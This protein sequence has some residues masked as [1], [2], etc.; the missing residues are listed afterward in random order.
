[1][2]KNLYQIWSPLVF[3]IIFTGCSTEGEKALDRVAE[4]R[5]PKRALTSRDLRFAK[6]QEDTRAKALEVEKKLLVRFCESK[7][8]ND[9]LERYIDKF[10]KREPKHRTCMKKKQEIVAARLRKYEEAAERRYQKHLQKVQVFL[11]K[12]DFKAARNYL[13]KNLRK[14]KKTKARLNERI[15]RGPERQDA[16][17]RNK[18][19]RHVTPARIIHQGETRRGTW[20]SPASSGFYI[21]I[22]GERIAFPIASV[23]KMKMG[24]VVGGGGRPRMIYLGRGKEKIG[25]YLFNGDTYYVQVVATTIELL[26]GTL[27]RGT[28]HR[29]QPGHRCYNCI[30]SFKEYNNPRYTNFYAGDLIEVNLGLAAQQAWYCPKNKVIYHGSSVSQCESPETERIRVSLTPWLK[31]AHD[32][33]DGLKV[34]GNVNVVR[35]SKSLP[36]AH[37][38]SS[39]AR[40]KNPSEAARKQAKRDM[41]KSAVKFVIDPRPGKGKEHLD[42]TID[43][44]K[45]TQRR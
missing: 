5:N 13:K 17:S 38:S 25:R 41:V 32:I 10:L 28:T 3:S 2:S 7:E 29:L 35:R 15:E 22:G 11:A 24:A 18:R 40:Q 43:A 31:E 12:R 23:K 39:P 37:S 44:A 20:E 27:I 6:E 34:N 33:I 1:M 16:L 21:M 8:V 36:S 30:G 42:N 9:W 14:D 19:L 26:D 4:M 45:R